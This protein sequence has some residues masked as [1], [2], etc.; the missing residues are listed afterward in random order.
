MTKG[1]TNR[2]KKTRPAMNKSK[3]I[4]KKMDKKK[5]TRNLKRSRSSVSSKTVAT[6]L[7]FSNVVEHVLKDDKS[8]NLTEDKI[9]ILNT[10]STVTEVPVDLSKTESVAGRSQDN[11]LSFASAKTSVI[12]HTSSLDKSILHEANSHREPV[13]KFFRVSPEP[14]SLVPDLT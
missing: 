14:K 7:G 13:I 12:V 4:S 10:A 11:E 2:K 5:E 1:S 3:P 8:G 9:S 6:T